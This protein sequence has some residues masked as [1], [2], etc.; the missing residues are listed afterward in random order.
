MISGDEVAADPKKVNAVLQWPTPTDLKGLRGFLGLTGYYRHFVQNYGRI[1]WPLTQLL[2]KDNFKWTEEAQVAFDKLKM[3]M[4]TLPV[5]AE[6]S[7]NKTFVVETDG[8]SKGVGVIL[9]QEGR[10][11]AYISHTLSE[12]AQNKSMYVKELMVIKNEDI[13]SWAG[14]LWFIQIKR[15]FISL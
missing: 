5:L 2:K 9:M 14:D 3:V 4:T 1:A 11:V 10:P 6:P 13:I 12:R 7:F 8:S 15:V